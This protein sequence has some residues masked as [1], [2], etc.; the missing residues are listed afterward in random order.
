M[1]FICLVINFKES[2]IYFNGHALNTDCTLTQSRS[3]TIKKDNPQNKFYQE[4]CPT[5]Q[6]PIINFE[7]I[8]ILN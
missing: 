7:E 2:Y 3:E 5:Y 4:M 1:S 8:E 6:M